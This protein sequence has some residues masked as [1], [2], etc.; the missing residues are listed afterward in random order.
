MIY[1]AIPKVLP[2]TPPGTLASPS[3]ALPTS[4]RVFVYQ[5]DYVHEKH[6]QDLLNN[7]FQLA[8]NELIWISVVGL[9]DL[10]LIKQLGDHFQLH[11]L[12]LEDVLG[13]HQRPKID[14]YD[15]YQFIVGKV[16]KLDHQLRQ[17]QISLFLGERFVISFLEAPTELV[18]TI[19]TALLNTHSKLCQHS[20]E[21]L[22]Y[23]ML[24][25]MIDGYFSVLSHY[26]DALDEQEADVLQGAAKHLVQKVQHIKR[27]LRVLKLFTWSHRDL[28]NI[29]VRNEKNIVKSDE[30]LYFRD[31][32]DHA[33]QQMDIIES[34][35]ELATSLLDIYLSTIANRLSSVM[36]TLTVISIVFMPPTFLAGVWGMNFKNIHELQWPNGYGFAWAMMGLSSTLAYIA[37]WYF[38]RKRVKL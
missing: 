3:K 31:C 1:R 7:Q 18:D 22:M 27:D 20:V 13:T 15:D 17:Q 37:L 32:H 26:S 33:V 30:I 9:K 25:F 10:A 24:D 14:I 21:Y 8:E 28:L 11:A 23:R 38:N 36:K 34:Q 16:V 12:A 5:K 35:K 6:L 19:A 2:G 4:T 29:L